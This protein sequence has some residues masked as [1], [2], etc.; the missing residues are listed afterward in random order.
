EARVQREAAELV[1][2]REWIEHR[3]DDGQH[4][5]GLAGAAAGGDAT[6]AVDGGDVVLPFAAL[7]EV[8][9]VADGGQHH[10]VD[11]R[12]DLVA[13]AKDAREPRGGEGDGGDA[14]AIRRAGSESDGEPRGTAGHVEP[15]QRV[16]ERLALDEDLVDR[17]DSRSGCRYAE[18]GRGDPLHP[19]T[20][21]IFRMTSST[22][23]DSI[24]LL[25][26]YDSTTWP[27]CPYGP[28]RAGLVGPYR[29]TTGVPR[30]AARCSGP[31]SP[32]TTSAAS[33]RS[34]ARARRS[35]RGASRA[36]VARA[37]SSSPGPQAANARSPNRC[38]S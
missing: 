34:C 29:P 27:S 12:L 9:C 23:I 3:F 37:S 20:S 26:E 10:A 24:D 25:F 22:P 28:L 38:A 16:I 8:L 4:L 2:Q 33:R 18:Q 36:P 5:V 31:V 6:G 15:G 1:D 21:A 17:F 32:P 35:V 13:H 19:I 11:E 30:A 7:V 14:K